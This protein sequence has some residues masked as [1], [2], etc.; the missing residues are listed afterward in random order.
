M[1][2]ILEKIQ[3]FLYL[4]SSLHFFI[5]IIFSKG[6]ISCHDILKKKERHLEIYF[7]QLLW[8]FAPLCEKS[9]SR[10]SDLRWKEMLSSFGQFYK[11]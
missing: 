11:V 8:C 1:Q 7:M 3:L 9:P 6:R 5:Q 4:K 2:I 10:Y